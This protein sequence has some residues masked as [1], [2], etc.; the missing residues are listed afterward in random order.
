MDQNLYYK[1][2][3]HIKIIYC[4]SLSIK[5]IDQQHNCSLKYYELTGTRAKIIYTMILTKMNYQNFEY[6]F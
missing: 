6:I 2:K 3:H 1:Q 4:D 5:N